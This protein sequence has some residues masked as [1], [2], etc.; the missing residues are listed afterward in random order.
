MGN[1]ESTLEGHTQSSVRIGTQG[2]G[3]VTPWETE[4]DLPAGVGGSPAEAGWWLCLTVRTRTLAAEVLGSIPW[5]EPSWSPPLAPPKSQ[6]GSSVGSPQGKQLT[7][8]ELSPNHQQTSGSKF[9][10]ALPTRATPTTTHHQSLPSGS[11][12]KPF[13]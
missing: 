10:Q 12:H 11:L 5:C 8:R 2:E 7:G 13:R 1:R 6:V 9:Y 3:A 4:P